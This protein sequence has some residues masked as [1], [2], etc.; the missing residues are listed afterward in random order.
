M[1]IPPSILIAMA[2]VLLLGA[3]VF[4]MATLLGVVLVILNIWDK[5][6][7][8]TDSF[9]TTSHVADVERNSDRRFTENK[10]AIHAN[11]ENSEHR[12]GEMSGQLTTINAQVNS[13]AIQLAELR[14]AIGIGKT[15]PELKGAS[16]A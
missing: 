9:A 12:F 10:E 16:L 7:P 6:R 13:I 1:E 5:I 4:G 15:A 8:R 3:L 11:R 2:G 14:G